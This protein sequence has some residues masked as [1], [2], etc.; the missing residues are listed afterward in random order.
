VNIMISS[1]FRGLALLAVIGVVALAGTLFAWSAWPAHAG[2]ATTPTA[3]AVAM[4]CE[5]GQQAMVRQAMVGREMQ[6]T[7]NCVSG[8]AQQAAFVDEYGRPVQ[9]V[10]AA[11]YPVAYAQPAALVRPVA[12]SVYAAP[13]PVRTAAPRAAVARSNGGRSWQKTA[14]VIGGSTGA[15]AGIGGIVGG[16]KGALIGAAIGG[17][18]A[19][20]YEAIK[21]R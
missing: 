5:P 15:G 10:G 1:G 11:A 20:I 14:L 19:S 13:A 8:A 21:R 4:N 6:V 3:S 9:A 2:G 12:P 7:I 17:G 16:K 18:G